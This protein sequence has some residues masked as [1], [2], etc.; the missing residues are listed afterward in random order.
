MTAALDPGALAR[1]RANFCGDDAE[2]RSIVASYLAEVPALLHALRQAAQRG[3]RRGSR[4]P[5]HTLKSLSETVGA[6]ELSRLAV[7][8]EAWAN[9]E[10]S[11][12]DPL[13]HIGRAEES[14]ALVRP[15]LLL[16]A[17]GPS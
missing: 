9:G 7:E 4:R 17:G 16:Q 14:F 11:L 10:A 1:L 15:S 8:L 5:A 12:D 3:D 2:V 13:A 6:S